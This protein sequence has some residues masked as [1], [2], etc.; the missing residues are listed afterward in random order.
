MILFHLQSLGAE[1]H[2]QHFL[3]KKKLKNKNILTIFFLKFYVFVY[4]F[5]CFV[6]FLMETDRKQK[7]MPARV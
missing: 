4:I 7:K 3:N 6:F 5:E 1:H 2:R